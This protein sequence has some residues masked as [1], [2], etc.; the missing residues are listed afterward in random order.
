MR[1]IV[2]SFDRTK[3]LRESEISDERVVCASTSDSRTV[4][5]DA[6]LVN[7]LAQLCVLPTQP[8]YLARCRVCALQYVCNVERSNDVGPRLGSDASCDDYPTDSRS[9]FSRAV[10]LRATRRD[11]TL[12]SCTSNTRYLLPNTININLAKTNANTVTRLTNRSAFSKYSLGGA[13][14]Y[15]SIGFKY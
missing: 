2:P 14:P 1:K 13:V 3:R 4:S 5:E 7:L 6:T 11:A 9:I 10:K 12:F 8:P 15:A